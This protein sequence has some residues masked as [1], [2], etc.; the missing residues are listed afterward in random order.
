M[1]INRLVQCRLF[2]LLARDV[3]EHHA[4]APGKCQLSLMRAFAVNELLIPLQCIDHLNGAVSRLSCR[5][6]DDL[7]PSIHDERPGL[8]GRLLNR[9]EPPIL[10]LK[11]QNAPAWMNDDKVRMRL[12]GADG[13]VIPE[14]VIVFELLLQPLGQASLARRHAPNARPHRR[15]QYRHFL[16]LHRA[17]EDTARTI[18][19]GIR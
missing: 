5:I 7:G 9:L 4:A 10:G 6:D 15:N 17:A 13:H 11:N 8:F 3:G 14:H 18:S 12:L 16:L 19:S 1:R 2:K